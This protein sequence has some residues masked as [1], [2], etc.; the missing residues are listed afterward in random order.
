MNEETQQTQQTQQYKLIIDYREK[1]LINELKN[2]GVLFDIENLSVGDI[3]IKNEN[4]EPIIMWER[5][6]SCDLETSIKDGRY[7]EQKNRILKLNCLR[8][9]YIL[10]ASKKLK[11]VELGFFS[12][13]NN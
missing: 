2:N 1:A 10:E 3:I 4:N 11:N 6:T 9:G 13:I 12:I 5:K 7:H 8:K